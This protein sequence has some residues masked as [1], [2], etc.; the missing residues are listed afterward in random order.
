[1]ERGQNDSA[2]PEVISILAERPQSEMAL[3]LAFRLSRHNQVDAPALLSRLLESHPSCARLADAVKFYNST[4][5]QDKARRIEQ[6]LTSCAPESLYYA[7]LLSESGRHGA[8]AAYLQQLV[9][10]NPFH[11]A[12]RRFLVEQLALDNQLSAAKLQATQLS[13]M[14]VNAPDYRKLAEDPLTAQDSKSQRADGF[15]QAN[16]FYVPYR[17]DGVD[18][19]RGSAQRTFSGGAAVVLLSDKAILMQRN[20]TVSVY[21]HRITRPLN[22]EGIGRYGEVA[23]PHGADLLEL[24]TIKSSGEVIEPELTQQKPTISMPALEPGD[25]IEEEYV[26]HYTALD[27]LPESAGSHTFGSFTAPILYSRLVLLNAQGAQ[28]RV[29]EQATPPQPLVGE[30]NGMVI[31]IWERNNIAQ[32][33]AESYLPAINLLP[34][35]TV[36]AAEKSRDQ[37][38][39]ELIEAT[40][41]G[42]HVNEAVAELQMGSQGLGETE[43]ARHLYRFVTDKIDSTG[44]G[45][46]DNPA[47]DTLSNRQGSRTMALLALAR[48]A[49][50]KA[51]LVLA[52]KVDQRCGR[53]HDFSCFTEPLVRF[54]FAAGEPVDVDAESDDLP[55]GVIPPSLD[56][57]EALLV[58]AL[59]EDEQK[60][61][62]VA[63]SNKL[64]HEKSV[65]E[66]DLSFHDGD[67]VADI[68]VQLGSVRAQEIRNM[69]RN[70]GDRERQAFFEQLA[71]RIFPG[72]TGV[73]GSAA[74]ENDPEQP[75]KLSLHCTSAQFINRQS[76]MADI[77]QLAP[78]LGLAALYATT[79]ERKFPLYIE[80]LFFESTVFHLHL[81]V[82]MEVRSLPADFADRS[83]FG[84]YTLRFVR[85]PHQVDIHRN[86]RI[87]VQVV[88]P[89][90]YSAFWKFTAQ[91]DDA[92]R[93]RISLDVM[94]DAAGP[95]PAHLK[96]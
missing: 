39:D 74:H 86:F 44:S 16:E 3:Q 66:G 8:A 34:T 89:E 6:Q 10:K 70:A 2:H 38:R 24:R 22:K 67:L 31:R 13:N 71:M 12:A 53:E 48:S 78:T 87:P 83:E 18:L 14:A 45:W 43:K 94:K 49:G 46:V 42:L 36:A 23:L 82:G 73:T 90:R 51:S 96:Q 26:M 80:S 69:L 84:E 91:I 76:S 29:R 33:I 32:T 5:E 77:D 85:W 28:I 56:T 61:E 9:A 79:T 11:R 4:A 62:L 68:Q 72:A 25:A 54:W 30:N 41:A 19:V 50:L 40:R 65:A 15:T 55:F 27:Q 58:Y 35:V 92:E 17:R 63:L 88:A 21:V 7:R 59:A 75:L 57:R 60:L 37:L 20:G 93:Q 81:P 47:E 64:A 1:M 95:Q 52:H